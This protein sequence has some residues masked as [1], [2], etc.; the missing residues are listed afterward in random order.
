MKA[1]VLIAVAVILLASVACARREQ[2]TP[3]RQPIA[4]MTVDT[5]VRLE[6]YAHYMQSNAR[7][8]LVDE[9]EEL[10]RML[11]SRTGT[12]VFDLKSGAEG[13]KLRVA[14][15]QID[16]QSARAGFAAVGGNTGAELF[17]VR[18]EKKAGR[19]EIVRWHLDA[20]S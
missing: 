18:L 12:A 5:E 1:R 8:Y 19:W 17:S 2:A 7:V 13:W 11:R 20:A 3:P 14:S 16:G 15:L 9:S 4:T 10:V 6:I